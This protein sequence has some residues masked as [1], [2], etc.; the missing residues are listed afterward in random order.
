[1]TASQPTIKTACQTTNCTLKNKSLNFFLR[2]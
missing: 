2:F 1:L